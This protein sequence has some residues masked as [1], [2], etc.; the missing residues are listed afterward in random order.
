MLQRF[1]YIY[2]HS[3]FN[4]RTCEIDETI[5]IVWINEIIH[6][7]RKPL[8]II[9]LTLMI[10]Y[11]CKIV[12][13]WPVF[14]PGK[15]S[16]YSKNTNHKSSAS[17]SMTQFLLLPDPLPPYPLNPSSPPPRNPTPTPPQ[18][19]QPPQP[20]TPNPE[21]YNILWLFWILFRAGRWRRKRWWERWS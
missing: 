6:F 7:N 4:Y 11:F 17:E 18:P 15:G 9:F 5:K 21:K 12:F 19:P 13:I 1:N 14:I 2:K 20:P 3:G 10:F 16:A 8:E